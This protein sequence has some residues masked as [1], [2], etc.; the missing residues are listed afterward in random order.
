SFLDSE[1]G[2]SGTLLGSVDDPDRE[3]VSDLRTEGYG[4]E[5]EVFFSPKGWKLY[6]RIFSGCDFHVGQGEPLYRTQKPLHR[7]GV[8]KTFFCDERVRA[9]LQAEG[10]YI[11]STLDYNYFLVI[12]VCLDLLLHRFPD[13]DELIP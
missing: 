6:Y 8:Q 10:I 9:R 12:D 2:V 1:I 7:F 5:A 3:G 11:D 13:S 4:G